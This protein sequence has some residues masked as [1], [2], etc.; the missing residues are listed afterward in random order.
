MTHANPGH[1]PRPAG[2]DR[3]ELPYATAVRNHTETYTEFVF[4]PGYDPT[5]SPEAG[6]TP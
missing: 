2:L 5:P 6:V 3:T 1:P 4:K